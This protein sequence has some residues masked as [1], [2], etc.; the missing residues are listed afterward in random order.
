MPYRMFQKKKF[1]VFFISEAEW[2]CI[3][4]KEKRFY[5]DFHLLGILVAYVIQLDSIPV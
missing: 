4:I 3:M 2:Q 1:M 5:S